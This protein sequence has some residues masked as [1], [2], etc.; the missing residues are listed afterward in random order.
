MSLLIS[1]WD[2]MIQ[3]LFLNTIRRLLH[4]TR[5]KHLREGRDWRFYES[6]SVVNIL[7]MKLNGSEEGKYETYSRK[8]EL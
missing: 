2:Y 4:Y 7:K 3:W 6:Y 5:M 8:E 1:A